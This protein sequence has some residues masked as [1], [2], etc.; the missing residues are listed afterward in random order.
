[1][2][3]YRFNPYSCRWEI[4]LLWRGLI[5]RTLRGESFTRLDHAKDFADNVGIIKQYKE[6]RPFNHTPITKEQANE[7]QS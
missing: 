4:Q 6:Q 1:M 2:Y 7:Q 5:W 3:R